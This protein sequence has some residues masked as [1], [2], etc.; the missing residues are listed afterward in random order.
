M[1]K[2][3]PLLK[4]EGD[5]VRGLPPYRSALIAAGA[6]GLCRIYWNE[7]LV[8]MTRHTWGHLEV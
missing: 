2:A 8:V 3:R 7:H 1:T 4:A 5:S 6:L